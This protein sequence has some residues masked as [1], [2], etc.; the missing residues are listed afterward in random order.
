MNTAEPDPAVSRSLWARLGSHIGLRLGLGFG[1]LC[2]L[3]AVMAAN[4]LWQTRSMQRQFTASVDAHV[5][6]L[7]QLQ[8]LARDVFAVNL[9]ARDALLA[10]DPGVAAAALARIE[11]GRTGIGEEI[12]RVQEGLKT[13]GEEAGQVGEQLGNQSSAMLVALL[14][15]TRLH[16]SGQAEPAKALL[17]S[18]A[19]PRLEAFAASVD[20]AQALQIARFEQTREAVAQAARAAQGVTAALVGA[21]LLAAGLLGWRITRSITRPVHATVRLAQGIAAGDLTGVLDVER[22]DEL[23]QLQR[24]V[25]DMQRQLSDLVGGICASVNH[26]T[27]ASGEIA[28]GSLV[29]SRRTEETASS[30]QTTAS[31]ME[32]L[33][34]AA[35]QS[36][37]SAQAANGMIVSASLAAGRGGEVVAQVVARMDEISSSSRRIVDITGVI[38]GIAFQTNILALNAAVEAARAGEQGRG[39]AVVAAEVRALAQRAA[40]AAREIKGL[41]GA[42]VQT[43]ES[44]SQLVKQAGESMGEIVSG[45]TRVTAIINHICATAGTQSAD[46]GR[47]SGAVTRLDEMT[48][49]NAA[50]VEESA[51]A[52]ES[53]RD[54]ARSLQVLVNRFRLAPQ[55][56]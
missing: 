54:Q 30:L 27:A 12:Q 48:Q 25:L 44:G 7:K 56:G 17:V 6:T 37:E 8:A 11:A 2:L 5:E 41:I 23:G 51:S 45:V 16:K 42:S 40:T 33:S 3:M 21:A 46:L 14:K 36:A 38:D 28:G 43:V 13:A 29:L 15:F 49:Q 4:T 31:A 32:D 18:V 52:A 22:G 53:L 55:A 50:L 47:A 10:A 35:R 19:L 34:G 26:I 24:A 9:A 20:R 39:F 1:L